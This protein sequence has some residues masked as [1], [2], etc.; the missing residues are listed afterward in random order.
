[1]LAGL[2]AANPG[3]AFWSVLHGGWTITG[4]ALAGGVIAAYVGLNFTGATVFTSQS[5]TMLETRRAL[6]FIG[7]SA[8]AG[9]VGQ[10]VGAI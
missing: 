4:A 6:P 9:L 5:G 10:I 7:G 1:M 8:I 3:G 2:A